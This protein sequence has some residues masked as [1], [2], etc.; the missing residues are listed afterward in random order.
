MRV[1]YVV[2]GGILL[3]LGRDM[4]TLKGQCYTLPSLWLQQLERLVCAAG[5]LL[6]EVIGRHGKTIERLH[7]T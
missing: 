5:G 7:R 2:P 1:K 3:H 4:V 6:T